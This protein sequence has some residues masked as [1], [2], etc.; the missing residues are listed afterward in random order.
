MRLLEYESKELFRKHGILVPKNA[1]IS[2]K[3]NIELE[4]KNFKFPAMLKAQVPIASR[5]KA[6][7]IRK[8]YSLEEVSAIA[9]QFL[10]KRVNGLYIEYILIEELIEIKQELYCSIIL[11]TF[12]RK[13]YLIASSEGGIDIEEMA[14]TKPG[15][16]KKI[17][18]S[19]NEGLTLDKVK[20]LASSL[21][22]QENIKEELQDLFIK[23]WNLTLKLE[24]TLVEINPLAITSFG[25]IALDAKVIVDDDASFRNN[26]IRNLLEKKMTPLEKIAKNYG[27]S[28]IEFKGDIGILANGAGLTMTIIDELAKNDLKA[29]NFL[30]VGGGA[31]QERV[32]KALE[33]LFQMHIKCIFINIFG[34]ITR[35]D[36]VAKAIIKVI[37]DFNK[38]PPLIIRLAGT[39]DKEGIS[40]LQKANINAFQRVQNAITKI[41]EIMIK[42]E[43]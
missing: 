19:L 38:I 40:L 35:C 11:D 36:I 31:S 28:F 20:A 43:G 16:I 42:K 1:L 4:L 32:Y 34:G 15:V 29:A 8:V 41:K 6:G 7:L 21:N 25:L 9:K 37:S 23:L 5:K 14:L 39:N 30:D 12:E 33:V 17:G 18:F 10:F 26:F 2:K 27:F 24:A 22:L 13:F 3:T